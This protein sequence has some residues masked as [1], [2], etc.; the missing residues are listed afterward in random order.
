[1]IE[2]KYKCSFQPLCFF[3]CLSWTRWTLKKVHWGIELAG[4]DDQ[5]IR[6]TPGCAHVNIHR[7]GWL[8][9]TLITL[10]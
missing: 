3:V 5:Y 8:K 9:L 6:L 10:Y 1:M 7:G 4:V 2:K